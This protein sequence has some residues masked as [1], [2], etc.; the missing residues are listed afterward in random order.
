MRSA[1]HAEVNPDSVTGQ[2]ADLFQPEPTHWRQILAMPEHVKKH[3]MHSFCQELR[4]L[5]KMNAFSKDVIVE[6][7]DEIIPVT[8]K[9]R[10]KLQSD[11]TIEK[12]KIRT[13]L[14]GDLQAP[15]ELDTWCAIAGFRA[16]KMFLSVATRTKCRACQ[17][18]FIGAFLQCYAID[19]T[20]TIL[21]E[22]WKELFPEHAEWFGMPLL[23]VKSTW[24][25]LCQPLL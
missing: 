4:T 16:L 18:D 6:E 20:I 9:H 10:A 23:C 22:E 24:R 3:W 5:F 11:G 8:A 21:P 13:C 15:S 2:L 7:T 14:R 1:Y 19:R 17:L 12:L 25:L